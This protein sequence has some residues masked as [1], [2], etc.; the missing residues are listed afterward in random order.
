[1]EALQSESEFDAGSVGFTNDPSYAGMLAATKDVSGMPIN[2]AAETSWTLYLDH[3]VPSAGGERYTRYNIN[4]RGERDQ[5]VN[6]DLKIGE[7]YLANL[8]F[9]WNLVMANGTQTFL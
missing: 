6:P 4:Y 1:M 3:T 2:D 5:G 7:L 9:G 8:Y